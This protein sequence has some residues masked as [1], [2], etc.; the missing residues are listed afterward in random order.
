MSADY[1]E[2]AY[3]N[4]LIEPFQNIGWEHIYG[5]DVERN[6]HSPFYDSV[7]EDSIRRFNPRASPAARKV[8]EIWTRMSSSM[9]LKSLLTSL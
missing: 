5:P 3:E 9:S 6:W 2:A 8:R 4:A 7:L 1:N